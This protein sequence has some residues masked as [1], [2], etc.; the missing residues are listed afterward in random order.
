MSDSFDRTRRGFLKRTAAASGLALSGLPGIL[1]AQQAPGIVA[2]DGARPMAAWGLQIG[3]VLADRAI[4]WSR[5]DKPARMVVE[6][7]MYQDLSDAVMLRGPYALA[8]TDMTSRID[9]TGLPA[10]EEIFVRVTYEDLDSG[11][12]RSEPVMGR[13]RTSPA[14]GRNS[15]RRDVR[16]LWGGSAADLA[17]GRPRGRQQLAGRQGPFG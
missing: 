10:D 5:S 11:K 8:G 14:L 3:D 1:R 13:F 9:L 6:W 12:A 2:A 15:R 16:F 7:S 17:V 4:V